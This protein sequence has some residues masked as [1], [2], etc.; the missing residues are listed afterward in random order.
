MQVNENNQLFTEVSAEES[1]IVSGGDSIVS[2]FSPSQTIWAL[3]AAAYTQL[4][5]GNA[6][7]AASV[8]NTQWNRAFSSLIT[9]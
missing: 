1:A 2:Q 3:G 9:F 5:T 4:T 7:L 6:V 8:L